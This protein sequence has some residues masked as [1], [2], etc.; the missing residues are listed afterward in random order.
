MTLVMSMPSLASWPAPTKS[1]SAIGIGWTLP[2]V[3]SIVIIAL[4]GAAKAAATSATATR[5]TARRTWRRI[6]VVAGILAL[7]MASL[8]PMSPSPVSAATH[9]YRVKGDLDLFHNSYFSGGRV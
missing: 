1:G 7:L 5:A 9:F 8:R 2:R 4:A 6:A 3:T